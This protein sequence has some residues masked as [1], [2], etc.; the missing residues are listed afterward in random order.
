MTLLALSLPASGPFVNSLTTISKF[1]TITASIAVVGV[2]LAI[3]F[4]LED[5]NGKLSAQSLRLRSAAFWSAILWVVAG[6][7]NIVLT[8]ANILGSQISVAMDFTT[9]RS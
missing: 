4:L 3:S 8:L 6:A 5:E 9:L 2:L 7:A 1:V